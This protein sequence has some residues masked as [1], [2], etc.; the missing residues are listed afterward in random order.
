MT[1]N[2][3]YSLDLGFKII[4]PDD[5]EFLPT[6]WTLAFRRRMDPDDEELRKVMS[7]ARMPFVA[8]RYDHGGT[9]YAYPTV[10]ITCRPISDAERINRGEILEL[11]RQQFEKIYKNIDIIDATTDMKISSFPANRIISKFNIFTS[12]GKEFKCLSRNYVVFVR[13][14]GFAIG[15]SGPSEDPH[16]R[17]G[18]FN[19]ILESIVIE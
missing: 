4:K 9:K 12:D 15:M 19:S 11:T 7:L 6:E 2:L 17:N 16:Q 14:L 13:K 3:F 18:D 5:W 10:Q 1:D 8:L